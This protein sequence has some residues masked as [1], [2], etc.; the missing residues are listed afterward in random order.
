MENGQMSNLNLKTAIISRFLIIFLLMLA[1]IFVPAW[2]IHYWQGWLYI[3]ILFIPSIFVVAYMY[4][5]HPEV[6]ER[7]IRFQEKRKEQ[8]AFMWMAY[9][10]ALLIYALPGLDHRFGW[11]VVPTSLVFLAAFVVFCSYFFTLWVIKTNTY[12]GRTIEVEADQ[13][14]IQTGPYAF[15]RHPMYLSNILLITCTP[16]TLGSFYGLIPVLLIIPVVV[17]RIL[18][19][20]KA[21][22]AELSGYNEYCE[23]VKFRLMPWVW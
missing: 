19:E 10:V 18:D 23:K 5:N 1:L 8:K 7:R 4:K 17:Y 12:A 11:S 16:L 9:P 6:I 22:R 20:E 14:V 13:K 3:G 15:I 2:T 21:L